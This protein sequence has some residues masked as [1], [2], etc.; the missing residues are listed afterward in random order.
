MSSVPFDPYHKWLGIPKRD[1]PAHHYRLLGIPLYE[2]DVQVVEAAADRQMAFLRKFQSGEHSADAMKLLNEVS[3]ARLCLLK[4]D[5]KAAYDESLRTVLEATETAI[6]E[7]P[8]PLPVTALSQRMWAHPAVLAGAGAGSVLLIALIVLLFTRSNS[9]PATV[10]VNPPG[11][12]AVENTPGAVTKTE[13]TVAPETGAKTSLKQAP[14][15]ASANQ[16]KIKTN[17]PVKNK[18][19]NSGVPEKSGNGAASS[20]KS[21]APPRVPMPIKLGPNAINLLAQADPN[22]G[23]RTGNAIPWKLENGLLVSAAK[24]QCNLIIPYALPDEYDLVLGL[25]GN[26]QGNYIFTMLFPA[27]ETPMQFLMD[28]KIP[29]QV[30]A[31]SDRK[32]GKAGMMVSKEPLLTTDRPIECL[33][34]VRQKRVVVSVDGKE[35]L[36]W[37]EPPLDERNRVGRMRQLMLMAIDSSFRVFRLEMSPHQSSPPSAEKDKPMLAAD[38]EKTSED[39]TDS[40]PEEPKLPTPDAAAQDAARKSVRDSFKVEYALAK[41]ADAKHLEAKINLAKTL[42]S[43]AEST[44]DN[45]AARY[46]MLSDAAEFAAESGQLSLAWEILNELEDQFDQ[47]A[48]PLMERAAKSAAKFAKSDEDIA[49][50]ASMYVLLLDEAVRLDDFETAAKAAPAA[51]GATRKHAMLKDQLAA[52]SKRISGLREAFELAKPAREILKVNINDETANLAW[53]R[54]VCFAKGD[55]SNGLP[56]LARSSDEKLASLASREIERP[57]ELQP[58]VQLGDDWWAVAEEEKDPV[59]TT[60]RER[61]VDAWQLAIPMAS[62]LQKKELEAKVERIFKPTK[63]FETTG[64]GQGMRVADPDLNPGPFFTVEFWIATQ[65]RSGILIS[66]REDRRDSGIVLAMDRGRPRFVI[67]K[68]DSE[69]ETGKSSRQAI[70][71]GRWHHIAVV[72]LG[73]RLGLFVD[74]KWTA[75]TEYAETYQ[76]ASPWKVGHDGLSKYSEPA[77]K[78]CRLRFSKDARYLLSFHPEK[79]YPRD[80]LTMFIP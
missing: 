74:G 32:S 73:S 35:I 63:F 23:T 47:P 50:V 37:D 39:A 4:P 9:T 41:K 7:R 22:H 42:M 36:T 66:K 57:R 3:R 10:V 58:L 20:P 29:Q 25:A 38:S 19:L 46:V 13:P 49:Y 44:S 60:I 65:S 48:L 26:A 2:D 59:R 64:S 30:L 77:A 78:F 79:N 53:G 70:N 52:H 71:D 27:Q 75:Q 24:G 76:S 15:V 14:L 54:Y 56:L 12:H 45:P 18:T 11:E 61:A 80:K 8:P 1:Q 72:K 21:A 62:G 68:S 31:N 16:N 43:R 40:A 28:A 67:G 34:Q 69:S 5:T 51:A 33:L 17:E 6:S 55:W